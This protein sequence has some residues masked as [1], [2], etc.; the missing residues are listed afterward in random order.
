[1][2]SSPSKTAFLFPGQGSQ[3]PGMGVDLASRS[4][5]AAQVLA[6][7]DTA[8]GDTPPLSHLMREGPAATLTLT[9][10]AQ[11]ALMATSLAAVRALEH[12]TQKPLATLGDFVAG[13]SLGEYSALTAAGV[14][15]IATAAR[16]LRTRGDAMQNAVPTGQGAM[17]VL[18]GAEIVAVESLIANLPQDKTSPQTS[19]VE[20]ANDNSPGQ[21]V[22]SG[23]SAAIQTAIDTASTSDSISIKRAMLLPVSAPFHCRL[24]APAA[25]TMAHALAATTLN[26]PSMP[27]FTNVS[28][29]PQTDPAVIRRQLTQQVTARVRWRETLLALAEAGTTR[30]IE[31]GTG[32]VLSGLVKR[33]LPDAEIYNIDKGDDVEAV[34]KLLT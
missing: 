17:A 12:A 29:A 9:R 1:M 14:F 31:L 34:A 23:E 8:L 26:I 2:P 33:T 7:I 20:I 16:L 25:D 13:H 27:I 22:I 21:I 32:K 28:A 11:P 18:L 24:M 30:F 4:P 5:A 10:H 3:A 6:T 15:D 19:P